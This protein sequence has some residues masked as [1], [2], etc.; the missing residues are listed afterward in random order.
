MF[1]YWSVKKYGNKLLPALENRYGIK[2]FYSPSEVR[3]TVYQK[4]FNPDLLPLGYLLFLNSTD[5]SSI[6]SQEFPSLTPESY[7]QEILAYL[8]TKQ[9]LGFTHLLNQH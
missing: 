4:D 5:L 3:S 7:K 9:Y 6:F 1:K 2:D 8:N